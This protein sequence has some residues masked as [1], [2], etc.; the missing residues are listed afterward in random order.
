MDALLAQTVINYM[1]I[2][3][4]NDCSSDNTLQIIE[5]Y[6]RDNPTVRITIVNQPSNMGI[7]AAR[8]I[9]TNMSKGLFVAMIDA[10]DWCDKTYYEDMLF[11]A[12][13]DTVT[14]ETFLDMRQRGVLHKLFNKYY[15][16]NPQKG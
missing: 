5:K 2:I 9:G 6:K 15:K 7:F 3:I 12:L 1:E 11:E 16:Q 13:P 10:D 14:K 8:V 4:I